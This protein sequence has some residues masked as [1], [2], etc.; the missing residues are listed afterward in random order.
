MHAEAFAWVEQVSKRI[1]APKRVMN[2]GGRD[3][4][5][6]IRQLFPS[7]REWIAVDAT[8]GDG[9]TVVADSAEYVHPDCD[10]VVSTELLEHTPLGAEIVLRAADSL[11]PGGHYI[12]T[13]A[14]PGRFAHGA[15]GDPAPGPDEHYQNIEPADL[16]RWLQDA[17]FTDIVIDRRTSP[18][19]EDVR[20]WAKKPGAP[21][22]HNIA[23][24]VPVV[25]RP[26]RAVP[27]METVQ[28]PAVYAICEKNDQASIDAWRKAGARVLVGDARTF[29]EKVNLAFKQTT[30]P[31]VLLVGDDVKFHMGWQEAVLKVAEQTGAQVIGTNDLM[32]PV[33]VERA[34]HPVISRAYVDDHG[35]SWDGP[36]V[37]A[38]EYRHWYVDDEI[39]AR[40]GQLGVWAY[41]PGAVIEHLHILNRKAEPDDIYQRAFASAESD[42][43]EFESRKAKF[44]TL[45]PVKSPRV[46]V[47]GIARDEEAHVERWARSALAEADVVV[48]V[49]TGSTDRTA[50]IAE[51][52]GVVVHRISV[53]PWRFDMARNTALA[54]LPGDVD[55][56]VSLDMDEWLEPG[57]RGALDKSWG[58]GIGTAKVTLRFVAS[59]AP[60]ADVTL[61]YLIDRVHHRQ[62]SKWV[63]PCH[64]V[65]VCPGRRVG[66]FPG[67]KIRHLP[68][69]EKD[70]SGRDTPLLALGVQENPN[71]AR[72]LYYYAR[73]LY[74]NN[75]W[76]QARDLFVKYLSMPGAQFDQER[77]EACRFI[78]RMVWPDQKEKWLLRACYEAPTRRECWGELAMLY[79]S[80]NLKREAAGVAS[81]VLSITTKDHSNS[82]HI[83]PWA[84]DD[85][86]FK[87]LIGAV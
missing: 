80:Q 48:M 57:W 20:A 35:A 76:T 67:V 84:W 51:D 82:F 74:Y 12:V 4:N 77:A 37:V 73:Q 17:G 24:L 1:G 87:E 9:V 11:R 8:E 25:G 32:A 16:K 60:E 69:N 72:A 45:H 59:E 64:E 2:Q 85:N 22:I 46:A 43:A 75:D 68:A 10:A 56:C 42:K 28:T 54:L 19:P 29:P 79:T 49:D 6:G 65:V 53:I 36:G 55:A 70:R 52:L 3:I 23:V 40:A 62:G 13:C 15:S 21:M 44:D 41:A 78:S 58:E 66:I 38:H 86:K 71:D 50:E 26:H 5:G 81:R 30:E 33:G 34:V 27:F 14:A 61:E 83:E 7:A 63:L 47:Y 31:W 18:Y 39:R